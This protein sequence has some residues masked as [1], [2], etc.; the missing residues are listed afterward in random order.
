MVKIMRITT[1]PVSLLVLLKNQLQFI[2]K[3]YQVVAISSGGEQL[4]QVT[5][6]TAVRTIAV[7]MTRKVTP[8]KDL[9]SLMNLIIQ[10]RKERPLIV[11]THTPKAG[12]LGMIA[13]KITGVPIRLH[14][15]AGLPLL[16][17]TGLT[18]KVLDLTEK[19]TYSCATKIY[20][21]STKMMDLLVGYQYCQ[22]SKLQVIGKGSSNGVDTTHFN[23]GLFTNDDIS[24]IRTQLGFLENDFVFSYIGRVV[25]DK[26][27]NELVESFVKINEVNNST[28]LLLVG[29]F[30]NDL[31]PL[32]EKTQQLIDNHPSIKRMGFVKDVRPYL[33]VANVFVFPSYREGFPNVLMQAG[34][35]GIPCI[36]TDINGCNEIIEHNENGLIIPVKDTVALYNAMHLLYN[37]RALLKS[38]A[39]SSRQKIRNDYETCYVMDELLKEYRYQIE[40]HLA[41]Q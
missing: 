11:H 1:V 8:F 12:L 24:K 17:K 6:E 32:Q 25:A 31:D 21:N 29:P 26:G 10:I 4:D 39:G 40:L 35:M 2:S 36:A 34:A 9:I 37:D 41:H 14:T 22:K 3:H 13:A 18:R 28:K 7:N 27:I 30:E 5:Q 19:V 20:P 33:I 15:V 16:E 23:P 38:L